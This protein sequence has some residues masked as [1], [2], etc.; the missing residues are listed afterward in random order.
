MCLANMQ[1]LAME[2]T[3]AGLCMRGTQS[4]PLFLAKVQS[5]RLGRENPQ[6]FVNTCRFVMNSRLDGGFIR[7]MR[8]CLT[9][10]TLCRAFG[11][12]DVVLF[13][14][15]APNFDEFSACT[16]AEAILGGVVRVS[17]LVAPLG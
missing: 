17:V 16:N 5:R 7:R 3:T 15:S 9:A 13:A 12:M 4:L 1:E 14:V 8:F 11:G 10:G 2:E 6:P